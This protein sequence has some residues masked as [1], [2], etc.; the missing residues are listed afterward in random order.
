M[1]KRVL[2]LSNGFK[3]PMIG[4]GTYKSTEEFG[5]KVILDAISCG[6]SY[7][8]TASFYKNETLVGAAVKNSGVKREDMI[9]ASK[10]WPADYGY[11]QTFKAF[12]TTLDKLGM[13][14]LDVYLMHWPKL[15][16]D[17]ANWKEKMQST[18]RAIEEIY[19]NGKIRAIG[20]SNFLPHHMEAL[21]ESATIMPMINQLELHV[22]YMQN[23][24]VEYCRKEKIA[25]QAWSPLGRRR[26]LEDESVLKMAAKYKKTPAQLLLGF[27]IQ[28]EIAVIPKAS[29]PERMKENLD[30]Y[31]FKLSK[32]DMY[33]LLC[34]NEI[35]WSGEHPDFNKLPSVEN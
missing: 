27:L 33:F 12:D 11:E 5:E 13:D 22:G 14:Y 4:F 35:G 25:V 7:F 3:L 8:D 24:A 6:Y 1:E 30:I 34:L 23:V 16:P 15:S 20:V 17:D 26:V 18:W 2:E 32:E 9:I 19:S 29:V 31:D 10:I 28:N 21:K